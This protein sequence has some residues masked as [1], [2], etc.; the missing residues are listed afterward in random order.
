MSAD[1]GPDRRAHPRYMC[2]V[3]VLCGTDEL[4]HRPAR[5]LDLSTG[6]A[7]IELLAPLPGEA[8]LRLT[9]PYGEG[10]PIVLTAAVNRVN[11]TRTG[12]EAGCAFTPPLT[13]EQLAAL[14][15]Q[16]A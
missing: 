5:L 11:R 13:E 10:R 2:W 1:P 6:G 9:L 16:L 4:L 14:L 3:E 8:D 12:W 7:R 15:G